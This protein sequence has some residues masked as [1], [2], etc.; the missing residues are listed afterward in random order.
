MRQIL[1]D[2]NSQW[3]LSQPVG[4]KLLLINLAIYNQ[5]RLVKGLMDEF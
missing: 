4:R 5:K 2:G 1:K 3:L